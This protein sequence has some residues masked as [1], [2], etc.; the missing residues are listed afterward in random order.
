[1]KLVEFSLKRR[2]TLSMMYL[3]V[4]GFAIFSYTQLKVD[5]YPDIQFPVVG[6]ITEYEG[7][8]PEDMENLI[9]RPIE[10]AVSATKNV[11]KVSSQVSQGICITM[12]EFEWGTDMDQ[13]ENDVRKRLDLVADFLPEE[14][15]KPLTFAF[16]PS[17]APVMY[18][19]LTSP[20]M[21]PAEIRQLSED[22]IEPLLERIEGVASAET[23]GGVERQINV[24]LNPA[25]LAAHHLS[26]VDITNAIRA[27]GALLSAGH[28]ETQ[29]TN[30]NLKIS[31]E[32]TSL[33]QIKNVVLKYTSRGPLLLKDVATVEDGFK[34]MVG[35]VRAD[36]NESVYIRIFKQSDANT[37]QTCRNVYRALPDIQETL[38]E[39]TRLETVWDQSEYI[40]QSISNL[41]TTGLLAFA[42]AFLVIYFFL[43]NIRGS[44][45]MGM[46]IPISVIATFAVMMMAGLTLNIVSMAGLALAIGMLVDN[47]IV[48]LENIY[49]H[50]EMGEPLY[51]SA[52]SGTSE[53]GMAITASTLT[54]IGVFLPVLFIPGIAGQLFKD[55]VVT[56]TFSLFA[57]LTIALTLVPMLSSRI[58]R[59]HQE[60][61]KVRMSRFKQRIS[62]FLRNLT[63]RYG[64]WLDWSLHH[65]KMVLTVTT[66]LF[67]ASLGLI[68]FIGGEFLPKTDQGFIAIDIM[69]ELGTP[70]DQTRL[71]VLQLEDIVKKKVPEA[72]H[73]FSR[74][75]QS[76]GI[77]ALF[78]G[79]GSEAINF[80]IR[81]TPMEKRKRSQFEIEDTLRKALDGIPGITYKFT[82]PG[83]LQG[84]REIEIKI[85]GYDI[86][87]S[88]KYAK[89]IKKE[90]EKI[91]GLVDIDINLKEGGEQLR[92]VPN[93][94]RLSDLKIN[95]LLLAQIVSNSI[96]GTVASRY[97]EKGDEYDINVRLDK[98]FRQDKEALRSLVIPTPTGRFV[99][100]RQVAD[101][102]RMP[103][104]TT[105]YRENQERYVSVG[106]DLSGIDL[107]S[108]V[109]KIQKIIKETAIPSDFQVVIGG[110][111]EDQRE[112]FRYII[113]AFFAAILLVYMIMASQFESLV[114]P[115][116]IMFTVPLSI[117]GVFFALFITGT[118]LSVM[119]LV[120]I[121]MLAG[122]VVNNGIV[123]VDYINQLRRKGVPLHQAV[124]QG[125]TVRMRPVLMT[126]TTTIL[127]MV[128]LALELGSGS[129]TWAP[130]A[131][132][133]IGGL[134]TSTV[135]TLF[136]VP[137]I[138]VLMEQMGSAVRRKLGWNNRNHLE[139]SEPKGID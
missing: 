60:A 44:I 87:R 89:Q 52:N 7:V 21:G 56:I 29:T 118:T 79:T 119:S 17:M 23:G 84:E 120:G 67:A 83:M 86:D 59:T 125:G 31:S 116:I 35:D 2:I 6:I 106:C 25:R 65:K 124:L 85:F 26:P 114:D 5:L 55:M 57:S 50:R 133:V 92:I 32:Y 121:V 73:V 70:L 20:N 98:R 49:R 19:V 132:A 22:H 16:D 40:N 107:S 47:S 123:M 34:E 51:D 104:P 101:I 131:R 36:Y 117:I 97:H 126:A 82:Q 30:F 80:R 71:T 43:L 24:R 75:G 42:L 28:I 102:V 10:E 134:T 78:G 45:I 115:F 66:L 1:M 138:Y 62:D 54:T 14:A 108:A 93:R 135:L 8:G 95:P 77:A 9:A 122:I 68:K 74:F 15:H 11:K 91:P 109:R 39:G 105:I 3:I 37:V 13:A 46:A 12:L 18:M 100:L 33:D 139:E 112:S 48:V 27:Q 99:Q 88:L 111:A 94:Q 136:I 76:E 96:Q 129:E 127:G 41:G 4:I 69:R 53:V 103:A 81:L 128:P 38:P 90:M 113:I 137:I 63:V 110:S 61:R 72:Q 64:R 58:L 130:L